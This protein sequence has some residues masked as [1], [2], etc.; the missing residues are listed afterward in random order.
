MENK[1]N[2]KKIISNEKEIKNNKIINFLT[3]LNFNL[4]IV[5]CNL[6]YLINNIDKFN[7]NIDF[8]NKAQDEILKSLDE[9]N[10]TISEKIKI[11][12]QENN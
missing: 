3:F 12:N 9:L 10:K 2:I 4:D 8:E 6:V 1:E 11:E 5:K 7:I